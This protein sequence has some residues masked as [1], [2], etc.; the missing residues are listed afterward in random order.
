MDI[1]WLKSTYPNY[2]EQIE[3]HT[4][5]KEQKPQT[6][7]S[8]ELNKDLKQ[9]LDELD[10]DLYTHQ[11]ETI[12]KYVEGE[13]VCVT[14]GTASGK[15]LAYALA[16][17]HRHKQ[18]PNTKN[19]LIFPTKALTRDQRKELKQ[20][21]RDLGLDLD[22]GIYDGDVSSNQKK[23]VRNNSDLILSNFTG[24]NLY[25]NKHSK[26]SQFF[27]NLD[28]VVIDEAHY[29]TGLMGMNVAWI[30]R[31]IRRIAK[32]YNKDPQFI[33]A[34]ATLG[35]PREHAEN[36]TGKEFSIIDEDG[37]GRGARTLL[38]WNPPMIGDNQRRSTHRES[39]ELL[40][41][42]AYHGYQ[43]LMFAPSRKM[44]ELDT[45]W[46]E[47]HLKEEYNTKEHEIS[48]YNAGHSK[49][50][51][52]GTEKKLKNAEIDGVVST[53]ALELG[54][55]I[56]TI[57]A[58]IL[59]GYPGK[60]INFWQ[61]IG[62]A[63][64]GQKESLSVLV[65]FNSAL[66][67]YIAHNPEHL[68]GEGVEDAV[69]D[70]SNNQVFSKHVLAASQELPI[71]HNDREILADRVGKA[72]KM[73]KKK[74]YLSGDLNKGYRYVKR[75]FPQSK[76]NLF[77]AQ[78]EYQLK[79]RSNE[80]TE[81]IPSVDKTRAYRDFHPN[82]VY[83]HQGQYY[84][85]QE[86]KEGKNPEIILRQVDTDYYTKSSSQTHISN[87]KKQETKKIGELRICRGTGQ[88]KIHYSHYQKKKI[89]NDEVMST[90]EIDLDPITIN[91][92][93]TWIEIP[94]ETKKELRETANQKTKNNEWKELKQNQTHYNGAI[95]ALEHTLIHMLPLIM[96]IDEEDVGGISHPDHP[97]LGR[98]AIFIYDEVKGGVG[99]AHD[100]YQRFK[101]LATKTK[102]HLEQCQCQSLRGCPA[103]T[104]SPNC[105]NDNKPLNRPLAIKL[106]NKMQIKEE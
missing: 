68:L 8:Q 73:W 25:M 89:S 54:I 63:G 34:S 95:H 37:S 43:T 9:K 61:Q 86:F 53:T 64:R 32:Y 1:N 99:F 30:V 49:K 90:K 12:D 29:Y 16:L 23:K 65:P 46:S 28:T 18:K 55:N 88:V 85:V 42:L 19:L 6:K 60:R 20:T 66:D 47:E 51:R 71:T 27:E 56:G 81:T 21:Y 104:Y 38:F 39:S 93:I 59:S 62:R 84:Q 45:V 69:I 17:A 35:N 10:L 75:D 22:I 74:E 76:I 92:Q 31:R 33:L 101:E 44:T 40:A 103:C 87:I 58:T 94:D 102:K 7:E 96:M 82:A 4:E 79:L 80:E 24:L 14:T 70:L 41:H 57:E 91:T 2:K 77:T 48:A 13:D 52:R 26:W 98:S 3:Y 67:Q 83:L 100:A 105:G 106:L 5:I 36:L 72:A 78:N 15:T 11:A 97:E 50:Q